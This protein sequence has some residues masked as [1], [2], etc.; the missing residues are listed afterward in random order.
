S[1]PTQSTASVDLD[2]LADDQLLALLRA[3]GLEVA[4]GD[5]AAGPVEVIEVAE[6]V[7]PPAVVE[8]PMEVEEPPAPVE[9]AKPPVEEPPA[10]VAAGDGSLAGRIVLDGDRPEVKALNIKA[11][12][13]AGCCEAGDSVDSTDRSLMISAAGGIANVVVTIEVDGASAAIP[14]EP[15]LMDQA[16]CRFEPHVSVVPVGAKIAFGNSDAVSHNIHTYA[17]KNGSL[18][19]T[20]AAGGSL[21]MTA[22]KAEPIKV[23][24]DIHPWMLS[25]AYVTDATH[26]AVT[27]AEGNF[28]IAGLPPGEYTVELWHETL[29]KSKEKIT[30]PATGGATAEFKLSADGGGGRRRRR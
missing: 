20:V 10:P 16:K 1:A 12:Q 9:E 15:I 24:C 30:V 23:A 17:T 2:S 25:W 26:W 19:K 6:P 7:D 18:N 27:D 4:V 21:E 3:R 22:E 13:A 5:T 14:T 29:G 11:E 8:E 28:S